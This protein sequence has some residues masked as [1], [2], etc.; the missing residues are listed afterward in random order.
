MNNL[1]RHRSRRTEL[2]ITK[3]LKLRVNLFS[4]GN[5]IDQWR[6]QWPCSA[7]RQPMRTMTLWSSS[8]K[9][10]SASSNARNMRRESPSQDNH[11][12]WKH[13][14]ML[15]ASSIS[16]GFCIHLWIKYWMEL[17]ENLMLILRSQ[18]RWLMTQLD[19]LVLK[20]EATLQISHSI[21]RWRCVPPTDCNRTSTQTKRHILRKEAHSLNP[22][23]LKQPSHKANQTNRKTA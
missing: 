3:L 10:T 23:I 17:R 22:L 4:I 2:S 11:K 1:K 19:T 12:W 9:T 8:S 18:Q 20:W 16:K 14:T 15:R 13:K 6:A 21:L 5:I 7:D